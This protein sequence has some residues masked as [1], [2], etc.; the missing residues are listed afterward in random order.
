[1]GEV[2]VVRAAKA[3]AVMV[4]ERWVMVEV[5]MAAAE[6]VAMA[7]AVVA[8]QGHPTAAAAKAVAMEVAGKG[9]RVVGGQS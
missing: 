2:A 3:A 8:P 4:A 6:R 7:V 9:T 5:G 1:L